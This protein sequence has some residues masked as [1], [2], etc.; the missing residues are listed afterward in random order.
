MS[1]FES[2]SA[3]TYTFGP[4]VF[5]PERQLLMR[6]D[7][8]VRIGGRALDILTLLVKRAGEVVGKADLMQ[9]VWP[10]LLVDEGNLKVNMAA[11]RRA[12]AAHSEGVFIETVPGE[13]YKFVAE[14][15]V[16]RFNAAKQPFA[17]PSNLPAAPRVFGR[18]K[19]IEALLAGLARGRL[20]SIVGTGG[21]G[22]TTVALAVADRSTDH[23]RDGV[24]L[25]D[26]APLREADLVANAVARAMGIEVH[27]ADVLTSICRQIHKQEILIVLDNCEHLTENVAA[28]A[29]RILE[30]AP[31]VRLLTTSREP[32][33]MVGEDVHILSGLATPPS[34]NTLTAAHA[35]TFPAIQLFADRAAERMDNFKLSDAD[36]FV[37]ADICRGLDGIALAIE[38]AAMRID[39]FGIRGLHSQI[40]DR[41]R[42]LAGRRGGLERHRT[43]SATLDW[44]YRLLPPSDAHMLRVVSVFVGPFNVSGASAVSGTTRDATAQALARLAAKSLLAIDHGAKDVSYRLLQTT[45]AYCLELLR[46]EDEE[47]LTRQRHA[48]YV[49]SILDEAAR[50]WGIRADGDW[51]ATYWSVIDELRNALHWAAQTDGAAFLQIRL[52][53]AGL[54]LWNHFSLTEE[55]RLHVEQAIGK[56]DMAQL[57]GSAYEMRLKVWLGNTTMFTR[58]LLQETIHTLQQA[59]AIA[60]ELDDTESMLRCLRNLGIHYLF[61]ANYHEG[62]AF[63]E[64]FAAIATERDKTAIPDNESHIAIGELFLG[65]LLS[66]RDRLERLR[67]IEIRH[68]Q[69]S[70]QLR[71]HSNR[72]VDVC[73]ILS[74]VQWL[75][76]LPDTAAELA[77][78]AIESAKASNHHLSLTSALSYACPVYFWIGDV[79]K[80]TLCLEMLQSIVDRHGFD[81]R[82]P[83][84]MFYRAA[85]TC[86]RGQASETGLYELERAVAYFR[87]KGHLARMPY[88]LG[89]QADFLAKAGQTKRAEE[90]I[91]AALEHANSR[92]EMWCLAE[93]LRIKA[94]IRISIGRTAEAEALL[95]RSIVVARDAGALSW[96][97]RSAT[98]LARLLTSE[99]RHREAYITLAPVVRTFAE[100]AWTR[101]RVAASQLL[102]KLVVFQNGDRSI[103]LWDR[104]RLAE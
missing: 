18:D 25:V 41:L 65:R 7:A 56:L 103:R 64:R 53:T 72:S 29:A 51:A 62:L 77:N 24:L 85:V 99:T 3:A 32:L 34:S 43:L 86:L 55:C 36:A 97:L 52:A 76:G 96:Q 75:T 70:P 10:N 48:E 12:L 49:L 38:L 67:V 57:S 98:D 101:D 44:S 39:I 82:R 9:H 73:C 63:L 45:R 46:S 71:Y 11:L 79:E 6:G 19:E 17:R 13:G 104:T 88:Y 42:L 16:G 94:S 78:T 66:A 2:E 33:N 91:V 93:L 30:A 60:T 21:I 31:A 20:I 23:F 90:K 8:A 5:V 80:C 22:K 89:V 14:V 50:E 84:P 28:C 69:T 61:T 37:V 95:A 40:E 81:V 54:L 47:W 15:D 4:F 35:M 26:F 102:E 87:A 68:S 58:G 100:G 1:V 59:L 74:Q 27:S 92:S 83:I